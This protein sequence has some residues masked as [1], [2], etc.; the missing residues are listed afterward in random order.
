VGKRLATTGIKRSDILLVIVVLVAVVLSVVLFLGQMP[1]IIDNPNGP[2]VSS[3]QIFDLAQDATE[4]T[5]I[6]YVENVGSEVAALDSGFN[7]EVNNIEIPLIEGAIDKE[8]IDPGEIATVDVPFKIAPDNALVVRILSSD[9]VLDESTVSDTS[10]LPNAYTLRV[11]VQG[12][13]MNKVTKIP[14][15]SSYPSGTIV[16]LIAESAGDWNFT[17]W[18]GDVI[19]GDNPVEI[20]VDSDKIV[21]A[22]FEL[23][24]PEVQITFT[25]TGLDAS[26]LGTILTIENT[27][28]SIDDFP[29]TLTMTRDVVLNYDFKEIVASDNNGVRF[30]L[31]SVSGPES[32]ILLTSDVSIMASFEVEYE[33]SFSTSPDVAEGSIQPDNTQ[34]FDKGEAVLVEAGSSK[35]EFEFFLWSS[36]NP[37]ITFESINSQSTNTIING[38]GIITANYRIPTVLEWIQE[39]NSMFLRRTQS[40]VGV[41]RSPNMDNSFEGLNGKDVRLIITA[42][43]ETQIE[44]VVTTFSLGRNQNGL[45]TYQFIPDVSGVWSIEVEFDGDEIFG[46]SQLSSVSFDVTEIPLFEVSFGQN[47]IDSGATMPTVNYRID[48]GKIIVESVPFNVLVEL[49]STIEYSYQDIIPIDSDS[50]YKLSSVSEAETLTVT[51]DVDIIGYYNIQYRF[52]FEQSGLDDSAIGTVVTIG[53]EAKTYDDLPYVDWFDSGT[54]YQFEETVRGGLFTR[55]ELQNPIGTFTISESDS[56]IGVYEIQFFFEVNSPEGLP[57][58]GEGWYSDGDTV[59]SSVNSPVVVSNS[60]EIIYTATG[61]EGTGSAPDGDQ[62]SVEFIINAPS[63]MT[64]NWRGV[65]KLYPDTIVDQNIPYSIGSDDHVD[66]VTDQGSPDSKYVYTE[67]SGSTRFIDYYSL[68]NTGVITGSIN[69][70]TVYAQCIGSEGN[71]DGR[72]YM[73]L[74]GTAVRNSEF[75][76]TQEW[77][78]YSYSRTSRP[79]GGSWTW[80]NI[81]DLQVGIELQLNNDQRVACT[82]VW[83]EV[84][85]IV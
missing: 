75:S 72:I 32:P 36:S 23:P 78:D 57:A 20:L 8:V 19:S 22:N 15:Q 79:G 29:I 17:E 31:V 42:P 58:T 63:T 77:I 48:N 68:Q 41:L 28:K 45:F 60:P 56:I 53:G 64:W 30:K 27:A 52:R 46:V 6:V 1:E 85:F 80:N 3:L 21:N 33:V 47:G 5:L 66:C 18:N 24:P 14:D 25:Q 7:V 13:S 50:R 11:N 84:E 4:S 73:R 39:P 12:D 81:N 49:D 34:W 59:S 38:P 2:N 35:S 26:A 74:G 43:N 16:T 51:G 67:N 54:N 10:T 55:F 44:A 40:V 65:A 62:T 76:L 69:R 37:S 71:A 70:V 82:L 9:G 61:Y 83:V